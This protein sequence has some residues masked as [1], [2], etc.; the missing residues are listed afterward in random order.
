MKFYKI[1]VSEDFFEDDLKDVEEEDDVK[2]VENEISILS[3][4]KD[5]LFISPFIN[6]FEGFSVK[7][8]KNSNVLFIYL[9]LELAFSSLQDYI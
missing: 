8:D 7:I 3:K 5:S 9:V 4:I 6:C 1:K 2:D